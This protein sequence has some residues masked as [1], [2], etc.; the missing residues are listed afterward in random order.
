MVW[1]YMGYII[2]LLPFD[3]FYIQGFVTELESMECE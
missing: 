1:L 2:Y 3:Y